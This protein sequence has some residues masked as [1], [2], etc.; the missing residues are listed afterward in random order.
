MIPDFFGNI[1]QQIEQWIQDLLKGVIESNLA[2]MFSSVNSSVSEIGI[3]VSK[4]PQEW[5]GDIFS[6]VKNLSETVIIPIAGMIIAAILCYE[7]IQM[8]IDKNNLNDSGTYIFFKWIFKA[9]IGIYLVS[10]VFDITLA[11][12]DVGRHVVNSATAVIAGSTNI[13]SAAMLS[14]A[15]AA[16][17]TMETSEL[18]VLVLIT[19]LLRFVMLGVSLLV[20]VM[21]V[22]RMIQVYLYCS[23]AP[24]PFSTMVNRD[25]G[26]TGQNYIKGLLALA[27]QGF[28]M[29]LCIGIYAK[30]VQNID[31]SG[32]LQVQLLKIAGLA[33]ALIMALFKTDGISK[34]IFGAS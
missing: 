21:L 14:Q 28:F 25:W 30:L 17:T 5:N 16:M 24:I 27:F 15:T 7:L 23:I 3:D 29:M 20:A 18:F 34:S 4:T 11:I 8:I 2:E 1:I 26:T 13:D 33:V 12:F 31:F 19:T 9:C 32:D 10:H 22:M 6:L